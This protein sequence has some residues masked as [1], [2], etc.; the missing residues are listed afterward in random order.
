MIS[1]SEAAKLSGG[2]GGGTSVGPLTEFGED[3][4]GGHSWGHSTFGVSM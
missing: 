4:R 3:G 2:G 1:P